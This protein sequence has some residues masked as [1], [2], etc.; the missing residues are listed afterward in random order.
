MMWEAAAAGA[1]TSAAGLMAWAVRG[2]SSQLLAPTEWRGPRKGRRVALTFDDGPS[3]STPRVAE[4]LQKHN[5]R[6]TFFVCGQNAER[7]PAM[8]RELAAA[9]H[10]IGNHTF[11]HPAL[12]LRHP[13]FVIDEL[14]LAQEAIRAAAGVTPALFRPTFGARWFG[15]REAQRR[16]NLTGVMWTR[17]ALD[18]K[19]KGGQVAARLETGIEDGAIFCLHDGREL[20]VNPDIASTLEGLNRLLPLLTAKGYEMVTVSDL[21]CTKTSPRE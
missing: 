10:E 5:A 13:Q 14:F 9:G 20:A 3:E 21:L 6:G 19:L 18:W 17:A 4:L 15:L 11:S 2:R 1:L 16:L 12:Y 8:V 7:L